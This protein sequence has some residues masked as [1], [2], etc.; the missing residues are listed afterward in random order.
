MTMKN[1]KARAIAIARTRDE[2]LARLRHLALLC[3][4]ASVT[5][6]ALAFAFAA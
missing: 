5:L 1:S 2:E 6:A 3:L 4:G